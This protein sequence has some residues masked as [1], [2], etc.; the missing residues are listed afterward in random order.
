MGIYDPLASARLKRQQ[1]LP[2]NREEKDALADYT[3]EWRTR[4]P[5][6]YMRSKRRMAARGRAMVRLARLHP[7]EM[8]ALLREEM[9]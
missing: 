2:L 8:A 9:R 7:E 3:R 4:K 5:A 1:G 6:S